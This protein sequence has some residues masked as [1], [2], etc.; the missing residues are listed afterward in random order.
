[1]AYEWLPSNQL[2]S[3]AKGHHG[4][5]NKTQHDVQHGGSIPHI[6]VVSLWHQSKDTQ[7]LPNSKGKR[8]TK[9]AY[10]YIF[11]ILYD[12]QSV[13]TKSC[14]LF[15]SENVIPLKNIFLL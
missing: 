1:M 10:E 5:E 4:S 12:Y 6:L 14:N 15:S 3:L 11:C 8:N 13:Y 7:S 2:P 9:S